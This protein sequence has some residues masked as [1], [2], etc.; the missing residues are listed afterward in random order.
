MAAN[1][2]LPRG[3][4]LSTT[5]IGPTGTPQLTVHGQGNIAHVITSLTLTIVYG[6]GGAGATF[7]IQLQDPITTVLQTFGLV[8]FDG[9]AIGASSIEWSGKIVTLM[10]N[11]VFVVTNPA[12][13]PTGYFGILTVAGYDI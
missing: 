4:E 9:V 7:S 2:E 1:D 12:T 3:W 10:G 13:L 5:V 8:S 6:G 11:D